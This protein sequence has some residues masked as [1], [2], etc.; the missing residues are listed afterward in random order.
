MRTI[1]LFFVASLIL[2]APAQA[3][4]KNELKSGVQLELFERGSGSLKGRVLSVSADS[5]TVVAD[6][7]STTRT[8][9]FSDVGPIK[10]RHRSHLRGLLM[11][12]LIG[13]A[14]GAL[15][16]AII[17][18]SDD[19]CGFFSC[20]RAENAFFAGA[21][22]GTGGLVA[23]SLIGVAAGWPTWNTISPRTQS[24]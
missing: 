7:G 22:F 1:S 19:S 13:T 9:A 4:T 21:V 20:G 18:G 15:S 11:G 3:Q 24:H 12:A 17:G 8:V 10:V 5:I 23:G 2:A 6:R 14:T 16:G